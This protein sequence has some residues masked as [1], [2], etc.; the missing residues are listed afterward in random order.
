MPRFAAN[1]TMLFNELPFLERFKAAA[2]A[3]AFCMVLEGVLAIQAGENPRLISDR[4]MT[5]VP[6]AERGEKDE[7][8]DGPALAEALGASKL[9][10]LTDVEGGYTFN[11]VTG[12]QSFIYD[13]AQDYAAQGTP[14]VILAY[15]GGLMMAGSRLFA[16]LWMLGRWTRSARPAPSAVTP[17]TRRTPRTSAQYMSHSAVAH[18]GST[19]HG[20]CVNAPSVSSV[21]AQNIS[22][23]S[24]YSSHFPLSW[25]R[26]RK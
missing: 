4:L 11:F 9:V 23:V 24:A 10:I 3:G 16:G 8:G 22:P 12:E 7:A 26:N 19:N 21:P 2:D 13:A 15:L 14:L 25:A 18:T 5:S 20:L 1:L 6:P 17:A